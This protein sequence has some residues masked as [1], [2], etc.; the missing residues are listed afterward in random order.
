ME[1]LESWDM[2]RVEVIPERKKVLV[3]LED[4]SRLYKL[5]IMFGD[6]LRCCGC[7]LGGKG[8][9]SEQDSILL[10]LNY[11]PRIF[12]RISGPGLT[13]KCSGDRYRVC[14][15]DFPFVWAR[16]TDFSSTSSFGR[17]CY[18]CMR[19]KDGL[20]S[21]KILKSLPYVEELGYLSLT[22]HELSWSSSLLVP[23]IGIPQNKTV[24]YEVIFQLNSLLHMQKISVGQLNGDLFDALS[25]LPLDLAAKILKKM[26]KLNSTC[27]EPV[28]F[29]Q[30]QVASIHK[31]QK[32]SQFDKSTFNENLMSCH[33]ALITPSKIYF[34]GPEVETSNYVV[35]YFSAHASNF[36]RV[37]FVEEDWSKLPADAL[38]TNIERGVFSKPYRTNI[39]ERILSILK[40]GIIM[41]SKKFEFLAFSASQLRSNSVWMFASSEDVTA[42]SIR[43]WMGHFDEI[44][45]V[46]KCA[47]RMGQLFS[48]S[49]QSFN[50][51]SQDV[52]S[53]LDIEV[54][55]DGVK[56][57]FS[58]GIGKI[59]LA[60][61][62][63]VA[64]KCGMSDTPSAFQIRYGG[65]K[66]VVTVDRTSFGKL[67]LRQSMKKFDSSN[68]MLNIT[69]CSDYL[70]CYLN[71][72]IICLLSTLGIEDEIFELMQQAEIHLLDQMLVESE[73]ALTV[74]DRLNGFE[75]KTTKTMLMHGYAPNSEP[76]ISM[77]LRA[78]RDYQLSD[79]RSRCRIFVPK[80]RLLIGCL[81]ETGTLNYGEVYLRI[82]MKGNERQQA[83]DHTFF[84]KADQTTAVLIGKVVVTKNPCLHPGDVRVLQAIYEPGLDEMGLVDCLV[85]PQK[86]PRPHPNE[87]SGG[88]LDGD[89][90]FVC[91]DENLI[92]QKT[93]EPMDYTGRK[94]RFLDHAVTEEE[95][96]KF[97]VDYMVNDTLGT[98]STTHL[99]YADKEPRKAR[100]PKCLQ[101]ANLHSM[102]V[103]YAKTGAPAEMPRI[104]KPKEFPD[105]MDRWDRPMYMSS[106][107]LGKLYRATLRKTDIERSEDTCFG[108]P[109]QSMYD[110]DL[111]VDGFEAFTEVA[112]EFRDLYSEKLSS[113]MTYYGAEYEDEILTGYLRNR[114]AY[115]QRDKRRYGE[116]R[117]RILLNV[118]NLQTEVK[119]WFDS[120]GSGSDMTK[121]ASACY[122]VTYHP[123][124]YS[125]SN[126]L[127]FPWIFGDILL[128]VKS[129][130]KLCR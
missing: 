34:L 65:Y 122:H 24:D 98:I 117:D 21:A 25:G 44:P 14:K 17:S 118:R 127:S 27:F 8:K 46:S 104:L 76:Y 101:L 18:L 43:E 116:M 128:S 6:L 28:Q 93:D 103:D 90:Y 71:R 112:E 125:A 111:E 115:L 42:K 33:R 64:R 47:A 114:S 73:A 55:T 40:N 62:G 41:G 86:G 5:E 49:M 105:F 56:Y 1:V 130:K 74:L 102:A 107:I 9:G 88:D 48:S 3:F 32:T 29:I 22:R 23:I 124:Y 69:N 35:K 7:F 126:F 51:P 84:D 20:S 38:L 54:V 12:E 53:I 99:V 57:C 97:F 91:W 81:D 63:Q 26:H 16:T 30:N 19:I 121:M 80:G 61:P 108:V 37:S 95:I 52:Q 70:P 96:Q 113:L 66:G 87:C 13:L 75:T 4:G 58:D 45:T 89:L 79:I 85:F 82:T 68:T 109:V 2:V 106:G 92:P 60:L 50:V 100:S 31:G 10:Q 72:E 11:A 67:S 129:S 123:N 78:C 59:S 39:Y 77:M 83:T 120:S 110:S 15:E 94:P 36:L 119:G